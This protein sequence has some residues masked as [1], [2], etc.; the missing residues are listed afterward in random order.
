[1]ASRSTSQSS[2][3]RSLLGMASRSTSQSSFVRSGG[4]GSG[5]TNADES[6]DNQ[7]TNPKYPLWVHVKRYSAGG[8]ESGR[9]GNSRFICRFC[10][11]DFPGSY[12]RVRAH[13]LKITGNGVKICT[14]IAHPV[15]EQ[16]RK[17][18]REATEAATNSAPKNQLIKLPPY[19][20]SSLPPSSKK[21]KGN[22]SNIADSF[23]AE[24]RHTADCNIA[25]M[26]Y[27]GGLHTNLVMCYTVLVLFVFQEY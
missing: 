25:K 26:F 15:V 10:D 13:L 11:G 5:S 19:E 7:Y 16:L 2:F 20:N 21:R 8:S 9:G 3:I 6:E 12:S 24:E 14:K 22:Q 23:T 17:E 4:T 18:D 1:M 27:T